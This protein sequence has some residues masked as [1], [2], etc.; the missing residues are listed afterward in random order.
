MCQVLIV[1]YKYGLSPEAAFK[2]KKLDLNLKK[3]LVKCSIWSIALLGA[4]TWTL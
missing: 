1:Y 2:E 4:A 3:K